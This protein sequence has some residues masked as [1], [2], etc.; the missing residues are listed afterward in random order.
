MNATKPDWLLRVLEAVPIAA[1][2]FNATGQITVI[3]ARAALLLATR[4]ESPSPEIPQEIYRSVQRV[5]AGQK[6]HEQGEAPVGDVWVSYSV[7]PLDDEIS[8]T[9][10]LVSLDSSRSQTATNDLLLMAAHQ[11]KTPLTAI[12]GGAQLLQRRALR[13][14]AESSQRDAQLLGMVAAQVDKLVEMVNSLLE[15]SRLNSGRIHLS[16]GAWP[17]D[18]VLREVVAQYQGRNL[19]TP[20][21]LDLPDEIP[22]AWCDRVRAVQ[23][24][25]TLL[26]N[27]AAYSKPDGAIVVQLTRQGELAVI[28]VRDS[29]SGVPEPDQTRIFD[30]FYQGRNARE[31]LGLGLYVAS[32][33]VKLH[34]GKLWLEETTEQGSTFRFTLPLD[35]E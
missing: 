29:G 10:A 27:A 24:V 8:G 7:S 5:L 34:G 4:R 16:L 26:V 11:L 32:E 22:R 17:L 2:A 19:P 6:E 25:Q 21:T 12:K 31:G 3:N 1:V 14:Q 33:L 30:R 20:V 28:S 13:N 18:E 35:Y 23:V 15:A 9:A